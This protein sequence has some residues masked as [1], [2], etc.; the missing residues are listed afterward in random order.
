LTNLKLRRGGFHYNQPA[1][2]KVAKLVVAA[3]RAMGTAPLQQRLS[4]LV[5]EEQ[6]VSETKSLPIQDEPGGGIDF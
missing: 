1:K 4:E 2:R 3:L 5:R 6:F